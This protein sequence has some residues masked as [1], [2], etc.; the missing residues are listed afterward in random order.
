M[1]AY[2]EHGV[3]TAGHAESVGVTV[4]LRVS[5]IWITGGYFIAFESR[6]PDQ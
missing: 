5:M 4:R 6:G 2:L 3:A 1:N